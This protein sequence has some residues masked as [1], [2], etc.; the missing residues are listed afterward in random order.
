MTPLA[1]EELQRP[2]LTPVLSGSK[3]HLDEAVIPSYSFIPQQ[4]FLCPQRFPLIRRAAA[5]QGQRGSLRCTCLPRGKAGPGA[6]GGPTSSMTTQICLTHS[7]MDCGIPA[8]VMARS[9]EL[10]SMSPA[11]WTC[12]PVLCKVYG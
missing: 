4:P 1:G 7:M 3:P 12:A 6:G 5:H 11:T 9:V 10:G 8:M 2:G